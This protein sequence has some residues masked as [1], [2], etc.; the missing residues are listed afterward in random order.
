MGEKKRE[1][2]G[3]RMTEEYVQL[4]KQQVVSLFVEIAE[5]RCQIIDLT[6]SRDEYENQ[7][8]NYLSQLTKCY[9]ANGELR[10]AKV[11]LSDKL[12]AIEKICQTFTLNDVCNECSPRDA[13]Y[14]NGCGAPLEELK[15]KIL[16]VIREANK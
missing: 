14:C 12:T 16:N 1:K 6:V 4:T 8:S 7:T 9:S 11:T 13:D 5:L 10:D 3:G 15:D 2:G